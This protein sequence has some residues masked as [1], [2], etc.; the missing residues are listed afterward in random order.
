MM[1]IG[2]HRI[3]NHMSMEYSFAG[4]R[5]LSGSL[6]PV[7]WHLSINM[8][9]LDKKGNKSREEAEYNSTIAY[10]KL[11]FWLDTNLP[12]IVVVDVT[13]EDDLYIANLSSNI[14]LYCPSEPY[15]DIIVQLLHSKLSALAEDNLLV[16]E[17][18]IKGSD[19]SVQYSFE[20]EANYNLPTTTAE[21]YVE[22]T[23]RDIEPWW[24]RNDGFSFEFIRPAD[25]D[26]TDDELFK[27]VVDPLDEFNKI[28]GEMSDN[29]GVKEPARIV[30]VEKWKPKKV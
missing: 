20:P 13:N 30:Q 23:A 9:A 4:I 5:I 11:F 15:D 14:M 12:G 3:K 1:Q 22:G 21:Y 26:I 19:M 29:I 25:T 2:K 16:G 10:Q 7:D 18:R 8:V 27:D 6:I 17:V 28:I 24:M